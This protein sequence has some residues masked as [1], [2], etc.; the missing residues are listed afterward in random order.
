MIDRREILFREFIC[1]HCGEPLDKSG[2]CPNEDEVSFIGC[3][4]IGV[5]QCSY[6]ECDCKGCE[7]EEL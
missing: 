1:K 6:E 5:L 2:S 7:K 3:E 4:Y